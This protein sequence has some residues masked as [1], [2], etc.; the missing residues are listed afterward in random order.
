MSV[1]VIFNHFSAILD[2]FR[3]MLGQF[4]SFLVLVAMSRIYIPTGDK[5][6]VIL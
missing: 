5:V 1:Q 6:I 3:F 2:H 4:R